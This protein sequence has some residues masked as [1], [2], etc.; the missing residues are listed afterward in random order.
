MHLDNT[1]NYSESWEIFMTNADQLF[2]S[3]ISESSYMYIFCPFLIKFRKYDYYFWSFYLATALILTLNRYFT[4]NQIMGL[5]WVLKLVQ[6]WKIPYISWIRLSYPHGQF[7]FT[8]YFLAK[9]YNIVNLLRFILYVQYKSQQFRKPICRLPNLNKLQLL[10]VLRRWEILSY[11]KLWPNSWM[12]SS[13]HSKKRFNFLCV[14]LTFVSKV[15][16]EF[17]YHVYDRPSPIH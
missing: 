16:D 15:D 7:F 12:K 6:W 14:F 8:N 13:Q 17:W 9:N 3:L 10:E 2:H 1:C 4:F 5:M 11:W